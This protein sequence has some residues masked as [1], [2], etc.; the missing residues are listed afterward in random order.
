MPGQK[1]ISN[2]FREA[3]VAAHQPGNGYKVIS[4]LSKVHHPTEKK[5]IP[6]RKTSQTAASLL[7]SGRPS[8]FSPRS[9]RE[10]QRN[11]Q[12]P[13]SSISVFTDL[14]IQTGTNFAIRTFA[15]LPLCAAL[16]EGHHH[17]QPGHSFQFGA[18]SLCQV[19]NPPPRPGEPPTC[20]N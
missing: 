17:V 11:D 3:T 9:E 18:S 2:D 8:R 7:R 5:F 15:V 20:A 19:L 6:K 16:C 14:S 12:K 10:A 1:N 13:K 4:R